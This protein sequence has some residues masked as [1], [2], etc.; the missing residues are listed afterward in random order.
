MMPMMKYPFEAS[1]D[2]LIADLDGFVSVVFASLESEFLVLP[3][4]SGFIDYPTFQRAY[5]A[6]RQA[7]DGF[8]VLEP[9][10]VLNAVRQTPLALVVLRAILGFTPPEWAY[11]TTQRTGVEVTQGTARALDRWAR[12]S[13]FAPLHRVGPPLEAMVTTACQLIA[14]PIP[15]V[16]T[17][18]LHRLDKADTRHGRA[19]LRHMSEMGPHTPCCSMNVSSVVLLPAT[20]IRYRSW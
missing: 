7:T 13:P 2:E 6:L 11:V 5:E 16:D 20:G 12:L 17:D 1:P 9:A 14:T 4:G 18:K 3:K 15:A 19:S 10:G 8:T